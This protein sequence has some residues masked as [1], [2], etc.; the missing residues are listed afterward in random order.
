LSSSKDNIIDFQQYKEKRKIQRTVPSAEKTALENDFQGKL[1]LNQE[2]A[3]MIIYCMRLG[4]E[5]FKIE[6]GE[7]TD[8]SGQS[9]KDL[10]TVN[11]LLDRIQYEVLKLRSEESYIV[12]LSFFELAFIVD[13]VEMTRSAVEKGIDVFQSEPGDKEDYR[14]WLDETFFYLL[15][16]YE[17]WQFYQ[18]Q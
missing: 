10:E 3:E 13:C 14:K 4:R 11:R 17:K 16:V 12:S 9:Q 18:G 7:I 6:A 2:D 8:E 5:Y 1:Q 15:D